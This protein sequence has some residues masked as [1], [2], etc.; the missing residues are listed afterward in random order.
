MTRWFGRRKIRAARGDALSFPASSAMFATV[1][2][3]ST[4]VDML[5]TIPFLSMLRSLW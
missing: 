1:Q 3:G 2:T 5:V 4:F